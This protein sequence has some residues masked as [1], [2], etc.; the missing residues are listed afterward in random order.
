MVE[1]K[2]LADVPSEK[3][4]HLHNGSIVR[5]LHELLSELKTMDDSIFSHHVSSTKNDFA[6]WIRSSIED[7][8]LAATLEKS[9]LKQDMIDTISQRIIDLERIFEL[10]KTKDLSKVKKIISPQERFS[11][12]F[13]I[14]VI[15]VLVFSIS[16]PIYMFYTVKLTESAQGFKIKEYGLNQTI[17]TLSD[18]INFLNKSYILLKETNDEKVSCQNIT[19][20][21]KPEDIP[22]PADHL[23]LRH[24]NAKRNLVEILVSNAMIVSFED[25]HSMDP[26]FD[27]DANA[28]E[29]MPSSPLDVSIGDIIAYQTE[30]IIQVHRVIEVGNDETGW[31]AITKGDNLFED[32]HKKIRFHSITGLV[33]GII[34]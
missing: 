31:Y 12:L 17:K 30:G 26:V 33:V 11:T 15:I 5:N 7:K 19:P 27:E 20:Q 21:L 25:S 23:S 9:S 32:D 4:F 8:E 28:I 2:F 16:L 13:M 34:Y 10:N 3:V 18:E 22:S 6:S 29:I 1:S 24:I 14:L